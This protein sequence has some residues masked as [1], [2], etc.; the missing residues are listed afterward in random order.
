MKRWIFKCFVKI[1]TMGYSAL[2]NVNRECKN[3]HFLQLSIHL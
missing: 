1:D 3:A 2:C